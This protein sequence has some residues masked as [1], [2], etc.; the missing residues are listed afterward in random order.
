MTLNDRGNA[1]MLE[2][3]IDKGFADHTQ[4]WHSSG[5]IPPLPQLVIYHF[6]V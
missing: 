3:N 1:Y 4:K 2:G 5:S 6:L